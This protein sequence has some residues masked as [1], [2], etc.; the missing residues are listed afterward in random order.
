MLMLP[1]RTS[2]QIVAELHIQLRISFFLSKEWDITG[3]SCV[4]GKKCIQIFM[5]VKE[6]LKMNA[7]YSAELKKVKG[8]N[9]K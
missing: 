3:V 9:V 5:P 2:F 8:G 6:C 1:E 4:G 7:N